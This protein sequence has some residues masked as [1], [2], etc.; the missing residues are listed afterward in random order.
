MWDCCGAAAAYRERF[1]TSPVTL[2]DGCVR[3]PAHCAEDRHAKTGRLRWPE[4]L[5]LREDPEAAA[6]RTDAVP[7]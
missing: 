7:G 2:A 1:A 3:A 4:R 6:A 5:Y